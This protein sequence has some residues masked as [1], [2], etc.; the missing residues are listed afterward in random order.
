MSIASGDTIF[1]EVN[2]KSILIVD[3]EVQIC[4][5]MADLLESRGYSI[6]M[7]HSGNEGVKLFQQSSFDLIVSDVRMP[8]GDGFE[9]ARQIGEIDENFKKI[10]F[11]TGYLDVET[12]PIPGNVK[13]YFKK[14]V[15]F[16]EL[17]SF[18]EELLDED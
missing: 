7:A 2:M 8:D 5:M 1:L 16:K 17:I 11:V 13:K 10:I 3:D 14:P 12:T 6:Q 18:I 4:E 9:L 15:R